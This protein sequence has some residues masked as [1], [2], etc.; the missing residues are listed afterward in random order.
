MTLITEIITVLIAI[1]IQFAYFILKKLP[2][3]SL[4][5]LTCL[6]A[7]VFYL[8]VNSMNSFLTCDETYIVYEPVNLAGDSLIMW[9]KGALRTT[10][11]VIGVPLA[12]LKSAGGFSLDL[13]A[14]AAKSLH[15]LIAFFL[16]LIIIELIIRINNEKL[17]IFNYLLF[18]YVIM[19]LPV[20][21]MAMKIINYD[22]LSMISGA[23]AILLF[24]YGWN[25]NRSRYFF[26]S[27]ALSTLAAQEKL[28]AAPLMWCCLCIIPLRS[29]LFEKNKFPDSV[30][31]CAVLS[32]QITLVSLFTMIFSFSSVSL[33][34][35]NHLPLVNALSIFYPV[36]SGFW[37]LL[38][39]FGV[40]STELMSN[41]L[42][43]GV[44]PIIMM[45]A[46][47]ICLVVI[48]T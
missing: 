38:R 42:F 33:I 3:R 48:I 25:I 17:L 40:E 32:V 10:D 4:L 47:V 34:N 19:L 35:H 14:I 1:F 8:S 18:I 6:T 15:W 2:L 20:M 26:A 27:I 22:S 24:I 12:L 39:S 5:L 36:V 31:A 28:I 13:L 43:N 23:L 9:Q 21:L 46:V 45:A 30:K 7:P 11:L 16:I 44:L 29:A 37:P 41:P